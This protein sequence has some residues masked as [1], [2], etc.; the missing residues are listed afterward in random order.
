MWL[1]LLDGA[2]SLSKPA[3]KQNP[4]SQVEYARESLSNEW[5][6]L[7]DTWDGV[8]AEW[9]DAVAARF[10][11]DFWSEW[12]TTVPPLLELLETLNEALDQASDAAC[13]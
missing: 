9:R 3:E 4:M 1:E 12:E 10:E 6:V 7:Q 13:K 5:R 2:Q 11:R 8:R